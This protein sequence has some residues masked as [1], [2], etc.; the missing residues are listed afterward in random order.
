MKILQGHFLDDGYQSV[1]ERLNKERIEIINKENRIAEQKRNKLRAKNEKFNELLNKR[2][3]K[4][5]RGIRLLKNLSNK[6][7]I[8]QLPPL[9]ALHIRY[10]SKT[11]RDHAHNGGLFN[12]S[13]VHTPLYLRHKPGERYL[14]VCS[15]HRLGYRS[16]LYRL[17]PL[18][19]WLYIGHVRRDT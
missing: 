7:F 18:G 15:R 5:I 8:N 9:F 16:Q 3:L 6:Y 2:L 13:N 14:L 11:K 10:H 19:Q 12:A 17:W 1:M 4:A